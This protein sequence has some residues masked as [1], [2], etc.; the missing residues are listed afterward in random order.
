MTIPDT[1]M[2]PDQIM[3]TLQ[4]FK[5][6]DVDY[7][8]GKIFAYTFHAGEEADDIVKKAYMLFLGENGLDPTSFPSL[9]RLEREVVRFIADL[10]RGGP[11]SVGNFTSG[12]TESIMLGVK[13][14]RDFA[15][16]AKPHI[17]QPEV[18]FPRTAHCAFY[19]ACEYLG[20]K[21]VVADFDPKTF[22]ADVDS[23]RAAITDNTVLLMA[24]APS[25]AQGV[26]DPIAEIGQLALEKDLLF[27][28]DACMGGIMLSFMRQMQGYDVPDFD[29]SAP[30]VTSI[31]ADMHKFGYAAKGASTVVYRDKALRRHQIFANTQSTTYALVNATLLSSKPGGPMAGA[32]AISRF[33][34]REGYENMFR[35]LMDA[36]QT[37]IDGI[38]ATG[39]LYVLGRPDMCIFSFAS[40]TINVF[41]LQDELGRRGWYVQPQFSTPS[42]PHNL[43]ITVTW[44]N[45]PMAQAF[46]DELPAAIQAVKDNPNK[47]D[48][49]MVR[50]QVKSMLE[51]FGDDAIAQLSAMAGVGGADMPREMALISTILDAL[52]KHMSEALLKD[53][54][55]DLFV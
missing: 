27:H 18:V 9:V 22:R 3:Q 25:Y 44:P 15:R 14:A 21:P 55:N 6:E 53:F 29:F 32:W 35:G 49:N 20:L 1:G 17:T 7:K 54:I 34:G 19:K 47:I 10:L 48:F 11:E 28:V 52:P 30:G 2:T 5:S 31:S 8:G 23:M 41:Q 51:S 26:V 38:N 36:T 24:S 39:D 37:I 33:L 50:A 40:D 4:K 42:S 46:V 13:T 12:G 16:A 43:H 45:V